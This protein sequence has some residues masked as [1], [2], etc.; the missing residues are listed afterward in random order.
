MCFLLLKRAIFISTL[1][2]K[3]EV[4][5]SV[6]CCSIVSGN[7]CRHPTVRQLHLKIITRA[8]SDSAW[9]C[10]ALRWLVCQLWCIASAQAFVL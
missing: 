10:N 6:W 4:N 5:K 8:V 1:L 9:L 2:S 3:P 7:G